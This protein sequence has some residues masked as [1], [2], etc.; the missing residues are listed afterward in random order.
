MGANMIETAA[1]LAVVLGALMIFGFL[2]RRG[3]FGL[4]MVGGQRMKLLESVALGDKQRVHLLEV[5]GEILLVGSS[6]HGVR[7]LKK[8]SEVRAQQAAPP[9]QPHRPGGKDDPRSGNRSGKPWLRLLLVF[10]IAA[11]GVLA[12]DRA[13]AQTVGPSISGGEGGA[14]FNISLDGATAPDRLSATLEVVAL[15]TVISLAP[16]ILL[17]ATCFTRILIV[18]TLLRQALGTASLPPNQ[19]LVGLSLFITFFVMSPVLDHVY[20]DAVLPY[21]EEKI[22]AETAMA[23]G[24]APIRDYL[25]ERTRENDLLLFLELSDQ[26]PPEDPSEVG[27]TTLLP[28]HMISEIRTAFEIG[29]MIYLPFLVIDLVIATMLI[30]LGM[31]MLPPVMISLPFK[32]MLFV[33]MDGWNLI[34]TALVAGLM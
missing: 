29:F 7:L 23:L 30:S 19:V 10:A 34:V 16:S 9:P 27:F 18:L 21:T 13:V 5:A 11:L 28:A 32:L 31:I 20:A 33:L 15:L 8:V 12:E 2:A 17:M 3:V 24:Q 25:L 6:E 4:G 14:S 1:A 26:E 22:D